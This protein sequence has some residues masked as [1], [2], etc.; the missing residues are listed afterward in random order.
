MLETDER[1][2]QGVEQVPTER[3]GRIRSSKV[4]RPIRDSDLFG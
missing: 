4:W 1:I 2:R 3:S